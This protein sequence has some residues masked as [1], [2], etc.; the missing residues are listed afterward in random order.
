MRWLL[1]AAVVLLCGC[2]PNEIKQYLV[3][4][5]ECCD[6][7]EASCAEIEAHGWQLPECGGCDE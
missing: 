6:G 4:C 5:A 7:D 1:I 2:G 3:L